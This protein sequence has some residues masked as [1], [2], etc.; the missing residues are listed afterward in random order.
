MSEFSLTTAKKRIHDLS[1]LLLSDFM[2]F[3]S[4]ILSH[5]LYFSYFIFFSPYFFKIFSFLSPLF[6]T[7]TLLL[8]AFLTLT[9]SFV[10]HGGGN[11]PNSDVS[12]L[13]TTCQTLVETLRSKVDDHES[14]G[15]FGC[16]G[17]IEALKIVF[18][19]SVILETR[20]NPDEV[21]DMESKG[22]RFQAV[23]EDPILPE[24][25]QKEVK[26]LSVESN[27][28]DEQK[29]DEFM[30]RGSKA[31]GN[32]VS[33]DGFEHA[34]KAT[35]NE[36]NYR[37]CHTMGSD[38]WSFGSMRKQK[39]WKRTLAC[40]LFEERHSQ[41]V[42]EG[43]GEGMDLLWETYE[44]DSNNKA[45]LKSGSKKGKKGGGGNNNGYFY[46]EDDDYEEESN[47]QVCCLQALKL[48]AGKMNLGMGRPN[49]VKISK[50]LKGIG[51]LHHVST[52]HGK[53]GYH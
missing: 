1:S 14:D 7:T 21:L 10:N 6:I 29:E 43:G 26:S 39:E 18:D 13:L 48:S 50:A 37:Y 5:P 12:F 4:F 38:V 27:K 40:K 28:V 36:D 44:T 35:V 45:Q 53:K 32:K 20:E 41:N 49:L 8:L 9:P 3:C 31:V 15:G 42:A 2:L 24:N 23:E 30:T 52:R 34:A 33:D 22:D 51:W 25:K 46:D 11:F 47:G 19:T 17:E 16:L